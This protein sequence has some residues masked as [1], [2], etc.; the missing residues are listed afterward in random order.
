MERNLTRYMELLERRLVTL[1]LL[2]AGLQQSREALTAVDLEAIH[3][4][5][6]QQENLCNEIRF[7]DTELEDFWKNIAAE[8]NINSGEKLD[9]LLDTASA[10]RFHVLLNTLSAVQVDVRRLNRVQAQLLSRSRRS[11]DVLINVLAGGTP[12]SSL[13]GSEPARAWK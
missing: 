10:R 3:Q 11:I 9:G 4:S 5:N 2:A 8:F 1:R 13:A 12:V 7:L 6:N